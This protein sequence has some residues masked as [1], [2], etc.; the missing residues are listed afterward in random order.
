[1]IIYRYIT[2]ELLLNFLISLVGLNLFLMMEKILRLSRL[3]SGIGTSFTRMAEI[4]LLVQPQLLMLTIPMAF[5]LSVLLT[6]GR[7]G[8]DNELIVMRTT[9]A[10]LPRISRPVVFLSLVLLIVT[11]SI[12][13]LLMPMAMKTLRSRVNGLLEE[14]VMTAIEPGVFFT[15]IDNMVVL[16]GGKDRNG[17]IKDIFIHDSRFSDEKVITAKRGRITPVPNG[18]H[19]QIMNGILHLIK[20]KESTAIEFGTYEMDIILGKELLGERKVEMTPVQLLSR[21]GQD[22][23]HRPDYMIEFH[24]RF[25]YP[26]LIIAI[27]LL[28]PG[29]S[30]LSGRMGRTGGFVTGILIFAIYYI[31]MIYAENMVKTGRVHHSFS[32]LPFLLLSALSIYIYRRTR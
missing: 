13:T 19:L 4:I 1:M 8:M 12:S 26:F 7:L 20:G 9:G 28:A 17:D 6:Y 27:A 16:A 30:L 22:P 29:L 24:R 2:K 23:K 25:S 14:R 3:L 5:L 32:W 11:L 31:L 18:I 15:L 21:A 10:S